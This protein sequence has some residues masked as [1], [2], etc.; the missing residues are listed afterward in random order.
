MSTQPKPLT[1]E[2]IGWVRVEPS[3]IRDGDRVRQ[4]A[5]SGEVFEWTQGEPLTVE[6]GRGAGMVYYIWPRPEPEPEPEPEPWTMIPEGRMNAA[7]DLIVNGIPGRYW[8][9]GDWVLV[10]VGGF[11]DYDTVFLLSDVETV[12]PLHRCDCEKGSQVS[13]QPKP[14]TADVDFNLV[15][16]VK[17]LIPHT[18]R[19]K[20]NGM[21]VD[22]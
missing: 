3:E 11:G 7:T 9:E 19:G 17:T 22:Q 14:P 18:L 8:R 10:V 6:L 2:E 4:E 21:G 1:A 13:T 20:R 15:E 5:V 16:I 12:E